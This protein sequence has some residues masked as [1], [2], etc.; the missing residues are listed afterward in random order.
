[1][2]FQIPKAIL[3]FFLDFLIVAIPKAEIHLPE[4]LLSL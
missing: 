4:A 1:M 2:A 3:A